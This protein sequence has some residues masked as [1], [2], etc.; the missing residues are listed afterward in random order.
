[1][2]ATKNPGSAGRRTGVVFGSYRRS[3]E[4]RNRTEKSI[5]FDAVN[6]AA[7]DNLGAVLHRLIPGG[8]F[9][10][11]EYVV[12]NPTRADASPGSFKIRVSGRREGSW[13][14][15][16][17]GDRGGD[18][19]SLCAFVEGCS[20]SDA[21]RKLSAMLGIEIGGRRHD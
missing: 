5:D 9:V 12:R 1:M 7:L 16:A 3:F 6:A 18:P 11:C 8:R 20:Q 13:C 10:A 14:D 19:V 15:F 2:T 21:A 4:Y 17:T